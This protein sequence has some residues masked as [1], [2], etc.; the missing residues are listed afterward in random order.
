M[1]TEAGTL[2]G[3]GD[4]KYTPDEKEEMKRQG[5][6]RD[7]MY[8]LN[9]IQQLQITDARFTQDPKFQGIIGQIRTA[10]DKVGAGPEPETPEEEAAPGEETPEE[11]P[12]RFISEDEGQKRVGAL[13]GKKTGP[14]MM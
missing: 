3:E 9:Q 6:L 11:N 7:A 1:M 5:A 2:M 10:L 13:F 12:G 14:G 4:D 8:A